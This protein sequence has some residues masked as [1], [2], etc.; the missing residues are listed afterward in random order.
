MADDD[1]DTEKSVKAPDDGTAVHQAKVRAIAMQHALS[2]EEKKKLRDK[3]LDMI[4]AVFDL[5][6]DETTDPANPAET[7][8]EAF[9]KCLAIFRPTDLDE[10]VQERNIDERCGYALC[11]NVIKDQSSTKVWDNSSGSFIDKVKGGWCSKKCQQRNDFVRAQLGLEP[12]W[13]RNET[14]KIRLMSDR[15]EVASPAKDSNL[16]EQEVK[17]ALA[18]ERGE[19]RG[20]YTDDIPIREKMITSIPEP[21]K[22]APEIT[23][24]DILEG[25]PVHRIGRKKLG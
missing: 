6:S 7:D 9:R 22:N 1:A 17:E 18:L 21:P 4:I 23:V 14:N 11:R 15:S 8:A 20:T 2:I 24:S 5:P 25:L 19:P 16:R 12:A 3:V 10:A 13:L